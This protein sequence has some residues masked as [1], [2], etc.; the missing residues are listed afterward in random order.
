MSEGDKHVVGLSTKFSN[1]PDSTTPRP[2]VPLGRRPALAAQAKAKEEANAK[3]KAQAQPPPSTQTET[4]SKAQTVVTAAQAT[5]KQQEPASTSL[6]SS[7]ATQKSKDPES[8][9]VVASEDPGSSV[10]T[11]ETKENE[12]TGEEE[13]GKEKE[14]IK[15]GKKVNEIKKEVTSIDVNTP[16]KRKEIRIYNKS[17]LVETTV[18]NPLTEEQ[19]LLYKQLYLDKFEEEDEAWR[20]QVLQE[21]IDGCTEDFGITVNPKCHTFRSY[22]EKLAVKV[23]D[24]DKPILWEKDDEIE[25]TK[26]EEY[27]YE[28]ENEDEDEDKDEDEDEDE[29]EAI[30]YEITISISLSDLHRL[31]TSI[32]VKESETQNASM[33]LDEAKAMADELYKV[34]PKES[35]RELYNRIIGNPESPFYT[36]PGEGIR[37]TGSYN[38]LTSMLTFNDTKVTKPSSIVDTVKI[39][40]KLLTDSEKLKLYTL[41]I[42]EMEILNYSAYATFVKDSN[43]SKIKIIINQKPVILSIDDCIKFTRKD[44]QNNDMETIAKIT[45]FDGNMSS[46]KAKGIYFLPW[47]VPEKRWATE[48][49]PSRMIDLAN[50]LDNGDWRTIIKQDICP[51]KT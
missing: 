19:E 8:S 9:V 14:P 37:N 4:V 5:T 17:F 26:E 3:R 21:V 51:D 30:E 42:T 34:F 13:T 25:E 43:L 33:T 29:D 1:W 31:L 6:V 49:S 48:I 41:F 24:E 27:K 40:N 50:P 18:Q 12:E 2:L 39:N 46:S 28:N 22:L 47:R 36:T 11:E 10:A 16:V 38:A 45:R 35:R 32:P 15:K 44:N 23:F 7:T 20:K